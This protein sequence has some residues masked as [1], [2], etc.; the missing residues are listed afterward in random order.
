MSEQCRGITK[1][2]ERCRIKGNL[3]DGYCRLHQVQEEDS[4]QGVGSGDISEQKSEPVLRRAPE[5]GLPEYIQVHRMFTRKRLCF[6]AF[7]IGML[8]MMVSARRKK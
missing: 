8:L 5:T 4:N 2:G 6:L 1:S 7:A 3:V